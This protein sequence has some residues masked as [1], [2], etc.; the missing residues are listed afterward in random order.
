[1]LS[2][3][4]VDCTEHR[5]LCSSNDV[6]GYPTLHY[7]RDGKRAEKYTGGRDPHSLIRFMDKKLLTVTDEQREALKSADVSTFTERPSDVS[8]YACHY[9][10]VFIYLFIVRF[11]HFC[12]LIIMMFS[13]VTVSCIWMHLDFFY[14]LW[15]R[16]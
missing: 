15:Q 11:L 16:V 14:R 2:M 3:H 6:K 8:R 9:P 7:F 12:L 1:M 13:L 4:Q 5:Q 10:S